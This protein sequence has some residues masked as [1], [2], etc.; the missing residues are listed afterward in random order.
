MT[1]D[2]SYDLLTGPQRTLARRLS[3]FAGGFR[4]DA[5]D[6][7]CG[8]DVDVLDG[9]DELVAKSWVTF[10]GAT[11]RYRLLE[12]IRQYLTE[13]F[14][15]AD[16]AENVR[17]AH[18]EWVASLCDRIGTRLLEDQRVRSRRLGEESSNIEVGLRWAQDH[19]PAIVAGIVGS[20]GQYWMYYD[21]A[22]GRRWCDTV[23]E[24]APAVPA[25]RW[26]RVLLSAGMI[27]QND[28]AWDRSV[29]RI[30][31]ALA[32]YRAEHATAG[33]VASLQWL[34]R[35]LSNWA[36]PDD[37]SEHAMEA[38]R[39]FEEGLRLSIERGDPVAAGWFRIWLGARAFWH[40]DLDLAERLAGQ[41]IDDCNAAGVRHPVGQ[42]LCNLGFIAH[43][44]G[45]DDAALEFL[46]DA[47]AL[48]RDLDDR[49][50]LGDLLVDVA[51]A[52][53]A[54]GRGADGLQALAESVRLERQIGRR[55]WRSFKLAVASVVHR[56]RGQPT[57]ANTAMGAFLAHRP[58]SMN[59]VRP[60]RSGGHIGWAADAVRTTQAQ[61]DSAEVDAATVAARSKALDE[62]MDELIVQ[63]AMDAT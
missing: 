12:P 47:A 62:L 16:A 55:P 56:A 3:V 38:T 34:G 39:C 18:A 42:A 27:A 49:W 45:R 26:A 6:A 29:A 33:Q 40:G 20:L 11:A 44:R 9:I 28:H 60:L 15:A 25:R 10:D 24:I 14:E 30:R 22:T 51:V 52:E 41:V 17:R 50:Q 13:H 35:A 36:D 37:N 5:V 46:H 19:D 32:I 43:W 1:L 59:W 48:F 54:L 53:A 2:W 21:Q 8:R 23:I 57:M 63:P 4:L 31:E 61:L 7:V 58:E